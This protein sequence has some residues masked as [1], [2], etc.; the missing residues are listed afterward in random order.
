MKIL[1]NL[2]LFSAL[3][4][5]TAQA[6]V[7]FFN[8]TDDRFTYE[9]VLP[10]GDTQAGEIK[11]SRG[12]GPSQTSF[13]NS[14]GDK[15]KFTVKD[16]TGATVFEDTGAYARCFVIAKG[17]GGVKFERASWYLDNGQSH[18][19]VMTLFNATDKPLTFDVIDEKEM[20]KIENLAPGASTTIM[21]KNGFGGSSGFHHLKFATHRLDKAAKAGYFVM[22]YN[23]KRDPGEVQADN[24]GHITAPKGLS[25]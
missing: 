18:K 13:E 20:R 23:D 22:L 7:F 5:G 2:V 16:E 14:K 9:V 4:L 6:D 21:A 19:R 12:Y 3:L 11:E 10:N 8:A 24:K 17:E 1:K 15:T 25:D